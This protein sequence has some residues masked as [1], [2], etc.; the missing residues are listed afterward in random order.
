MPERR[1]LHAGSAG[2]VALAIAIAGCGG[3]SSNSDTGTGAASSPA[4]TP[5]AR[6]TTPTPATTPTTRTNRGGG[7]VAAG[8]AVFTS[9]CGTCHTLKDA[10]TTGT[11]GP[12]LDNLMPDR[13][14]VVRQVTNGGAGM[15]AFRGQL[16]AAQIVAVARYVS[17][18]AGRS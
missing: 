18:V 10:G 4:T 12:N 16:S 13:A 11:A 14:T 17:S 9:N 1:L 5:S 7:S 15:P 8:R 2:L 6:A 3:G